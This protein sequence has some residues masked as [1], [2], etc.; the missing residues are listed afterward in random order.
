VKAAGWSAAPLIF[1]ICWWALPTPAL[2]AQIT[3]EEY[4]RIE[5][6][7]TYKETVAIVGEEGKVDWENESQYTGHL[8][9]V[10][11]SAGGRSFALCHFARGRVSDKSW[12]TP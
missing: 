10:Q 2:P 6:G 3:R 4:D 5:V 9:E 8:A 12:Y 7:M 1:F 11:W